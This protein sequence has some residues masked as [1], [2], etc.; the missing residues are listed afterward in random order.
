MQHFFP[1]RKRATNSKF[2]EQYKRFVLADE[3]K[4]SPT[5][6]NGDGFYMACVANS[7]KKYKNSRRIYI[8]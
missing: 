8:A 2:L 7:M 1:Q 3:C 6:Y 5:N 4:L